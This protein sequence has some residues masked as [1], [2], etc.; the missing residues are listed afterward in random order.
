MF[1]YLFRLKILFICINTIYVFYILV[2]ILLLVLLLG[3]ERVTL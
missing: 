1:I 3:R 2:K